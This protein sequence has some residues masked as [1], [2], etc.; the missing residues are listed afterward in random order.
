M[1]SSL[2]FSVLLAAAQPAPSILLPAQPVGEPIDCN[3][4]VVKAQI[5][6]DDVVCR[7]VSRSKLKI[8]DQTITLR[9]LHD[10]EEDATLPP[11]YAEAAYEAIARSFEIA[12]KERKLNF[13]NVSI[14]AVE[15][16]GQRREAR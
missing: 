8:G 9:L 15:A 7:E 14:L 11:G 16:Y 5:F 10:D 6:N 2:L 3:G 1:F 12:A 4:A 13:H